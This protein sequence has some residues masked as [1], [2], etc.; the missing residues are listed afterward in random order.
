[1][2]FNTSK[3]NSYFLCSHKG[4]ENLVVIYE[5]IRGSFE[6]DTLGKHHPI[7]FS[8]QE[9]LKVVI[10]ITRCIAVTW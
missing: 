10:P 5:I 8:L 6:F 1:M 9:T 3:S 7:D 4:I 2:H